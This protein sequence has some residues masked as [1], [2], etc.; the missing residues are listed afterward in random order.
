MKIFV[1]AWVGA[2]VPIALAGCPNQITLGDGGTNPATDAGQA[3]DGGT[4]SSD[5]GC[6]TGTEGCVCFSNGTCFD[7]LSCSADSVCEPCPPGEPGCPCSEDE[8]CSAGLTCGDDGL[9]ACL[10]G[11]DG[12]PCFGN[13][14]CEDPF[15]CD[16]TNTCRCPAG[17][18]DCPCLSGGNCSGLLTCEADDVCRCTAG[19][20]G[21]ACDAG[22]CEA[23]LFCGDD[24]I[25][26]DPPPP[27]P[28][29]TF[30]CGCDIGDTCEVG[31]A[32]LAGTCLDD[33]DPGTCHWA[34]YNHMCGDDVDNRLFET[35]INGVPG[36]LD[37]ANDRYVT[38][39]G[40]LFVDS[41]CWDMIPN[42]VEG[43]DDEPGACAEQI[44]CAGAPQGYCN[45]NWA[46]LVPPSFTAGFSA[47][48]DACAPGLT[49]LAEGDA[50]TQ[51]GEVLVS[52]TCVLDNGYD[53]TPC[54]PGEVRRGCFGDVV[55]EC[56]QPWQGPP[57]AGFPY[58]SNL[59]LKTANAV[60]CASVFE[61]QCVERLGKGACL[62]TTACE[63]DGFRGCGTDG[64]FGNWGCNLAAMFP[65]SQGGSNAE[66]GACVDGVG[67]CTPGEAAHCSG[68]FLTVRCAEYGQRI[69][70]DCTQFAG[71]TCVT[72]GGPHCRVTNGAPCGRDLQ[73]MDD[74]TFK[75]ANGYQ[76]NEQG[77]CEPK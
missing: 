9:C 58:Q 55:S 36:T 7:E 53:D 32:C 68:D 46:R 57:T 66:Y 1:L 12:C 31:L 22:S 73:G 43:P 77:T 52:E 63:Y 40:P 72:S 21:C 26:G 13:G 42:C 75:C 65:T 15:R 5:A 16:A 38:P 11:T 18:E 6:E 20:E 51:P 64:D 23:G 3:V 19:T 67:V 69:G 28:D 50:L 25:C 39:D 41:L 61:T 62:S 59:T 24:D 4:A 56:G 8:S 2:L 44:G 54:E 37:C 71:G 29:G 70:I 10:A 33:G 49:C 60:D 14:T 48:I 45:V 27:C 76:C 30:G 35:C 17:T 47:P 74:A 34:T